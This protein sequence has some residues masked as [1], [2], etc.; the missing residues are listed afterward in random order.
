MIKAIFLDF[1]GVI[2]ESVNLK[3]D[4]YRELFSRYPDHVE[5][6]LSYHLE[7]NALS[8]YIKFRHIYENI[9]NKPYSPKTE[10]ELDEEFSNIVFRKVV[11]C[12]YVPGALE[13][14]NFFVNKRSLFLVSATPE[15][16]LEKI[17]Q[18]RNI[19]HYF[20]KAVGAPGRKADHINSILRSEQLQPGEVIYVGDMNEDLRI[21]KALGVLFVGRKNTELFEDPRIVSYPDMTGIQMWIIK[22]QNTQLF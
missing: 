18:A 21:A 2:V 12:P 3:T 17:L 22:N 7:H 4:S 13:F 6:I 14:L 9:L 10:Y 16:E 15:W 19:R 5:E 20:T 11:S 8:R 1:D